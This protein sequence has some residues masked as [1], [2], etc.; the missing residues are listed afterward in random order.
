MLM[1]KFLISIMSTVLSACILMSATSFANQ[2]SP[3][4]DFQQILDSFLAMMK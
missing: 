4:N 2:I 3:E 1:K